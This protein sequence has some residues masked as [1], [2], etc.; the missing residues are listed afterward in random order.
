MVMEEDERNVEQECRDL[1]EAYQR[2]PQQEA[3]LPW[4]RIQLHIAGLTAVGFGPGTELLLVL[5]HSGRGVVDC[6][7]GLVV[8]RD[9]EDVDLPDGPYPVFAPGIGPLA[10]QRV[11]L[12]GLWGG[13]LRTMSPDGWVIHR[14]APNWPLE[15]AVLCPPHAKEIED[16]ATATVLLKDLNPEIRAFGFSDS[17]NTLIVAN[18]ALHLWSR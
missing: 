17:G 9:Y 14:A 4:R 3:P 15:S 8:A 7:S 12:A 18:T 1:R 11:P 10:G 6:A 2:K 13:G 5:S 16:E